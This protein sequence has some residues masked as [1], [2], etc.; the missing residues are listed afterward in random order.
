MLKQI[1]MIAVMTLGLA[2]CQRGPQGDLGPMGP[3]GSNGQPAEPARVYY[4]NNNFDTASGVSEWQSS[5]T[6]LPC[7]CYMAAVLD[8][9]KF[10]SAGTSMKVSASAAADSLIYTPFTYAGGKIGVEAAFD[11]SAVPVNAGFNNVS[12]IIAQGG[13][14]RAAI[15]FNPGTGSGGNIYAMNGG[16]PVNVFGA[17]NTNYFRTLRAIWDS[18]TGLAD[19]YVDGYLVGQ[20][21]NSTTSFAFAGAP[22]AFAGV[23]ARNNGTW[24]VR[25]DNFQI[26]H[27]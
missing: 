20:G 26:F 25:A 4:Y 16:S 1:S 22:S 21:F 7:S 13:S 11:F 12:L 23:H 6:G 14:I 8:T 10:L 2:A 5:L 3:S 15:G 24:V 17:P 27:Y 9:T 19:Y 18:N